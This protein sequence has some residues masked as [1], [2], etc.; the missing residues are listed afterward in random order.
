MFCFVSISI[1][2][3]PTLWNDRFGKKNTVKI[4]VPFNRIKGNIE[5]VNKIFLILS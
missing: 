3:S 5:I 1:L 2:N 4:L